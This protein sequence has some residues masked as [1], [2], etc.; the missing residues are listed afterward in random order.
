MGQN[1]KVSLSMWL[2]LTRVI[3]RLHAVPVQF[4]S[5]LQELRKSRQLSEWHPLSKKGEL[6]EEERTL[7]FGAEYGGCQKPEDTNDPFF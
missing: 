7:E 6:V 2:V 1:R 3:W 4:W 5:R